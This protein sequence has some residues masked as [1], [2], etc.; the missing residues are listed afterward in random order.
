MDKTQDLNSLLLWKR[1][2]HS[3]QNSFKSSTSTINNLYQIFRRQLKL[4]EIDFH[5][6]W[7]KTKPF[8]F[9]SQILIKVIIR[10]PWQSLFHIGSTIQ[11]FR[12]KCIY[13]KSINHFYF[14]LYFIFQTWKL[15]YDKNYFPL[16]FLVAFNFYSV[17]AVDIAFN[18]FIDSIQL[19][20][21]GAW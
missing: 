21:Y 20:I 6:K 1:S 4:S 13:E 19:E 7:T 10:L 15:Y 3:L 12:I 17:C 5:H 2:S 14:L 16:I 8:N 18:D 11:L 9:Q